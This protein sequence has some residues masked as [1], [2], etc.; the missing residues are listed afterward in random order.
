VFQ[1]KRLTDPAGANDPRTH[2]WVLLYAQV[3]Q[4]DGATRR[5]VLIAR[6]PAIPRLDV[7]NGKPVPPQT[8]D[9]MSVAQFDEPS[10]E[11]KLAD[12]ALPS[13]SPLSVLAVE[14]LPS[15]HL[16]QQTVMIGDAQ[17]YLTFDQP[18]PF[19]DPQQPSFGG[20][21]AAPHGRSSGARAWQSDEPPYPPLFSAHAGR[22][23]LLIRC[24][25]GNSIRLVG[26]D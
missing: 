8:R 1:D 21:I 24:V 26:T 23:G 9:V 7:V 11:Q 15:D 2:I 10:I 13:D 14:L 4:A 22:A 18:D 3:M 25:I 17:V 19:A 12:L 16:V 6:A 5:N 20:F